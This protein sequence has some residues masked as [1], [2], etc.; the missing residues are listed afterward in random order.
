MHLP[1]FFRNVFGRRNPLDPGNLGARVRDVSFRVMDDADIPI[2]LAIYRA[3]EAAHFPRGFF[4]RYEAHL[5]SG[6][7]LNLMTMRDGEPVGCGGLVY[8][9]NGEAWLCFGM[10]APSHQRQGLGTAMFLARL[11]LLTPVGG[12]STIRI[13][14]VPGSMAFYRRFGFLFAQGSSNVGGVFHPVGTLHLRAA[15]IEACRTI[16]AERR[17]SYPNIS[18]K[19]PRGAGRLG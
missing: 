7:F 2:C 1:N 19:I 14:A 15:E 12:W 5:R 18:D 4:E 8:D 3:N 10:L 9:G 13:A 17:I 16:L 6:R 11:A